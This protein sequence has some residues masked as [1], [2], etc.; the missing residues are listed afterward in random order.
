MA[1]SARCRRDL[2]HR[3]SRKGSAGPGVRRRAGTTGST[4]RHA[5]DS[6]SNRC[7]H[8]DLLT[9]VAEEVGAAGIALQ[10]PRGVLVV[11]VEL[12]EQRPFTPGSHTLLTLLAARLGQGLHRVYQLDEQ[13]ETASGPA[14]RHARPPTL[15]EGFAVRYRPANRPLQVGGDWYDVVDL[16][17]GRIAVIVGD[18]VGH[19]L[20]R[21]HRDGSAAQRLPR[22]AARAAQSR[23]GAGRAPTASLRVCRSPDAPPHSAQCSTPPPVNS[24]TPARAIRRRSWCTPTAPPSGWTADTGY[25]WR[26]RGTGPD[27]KPASRCRRAATL[28]LY[29]DG[30]VER[31]GTSI[32]DGMARAADL[33]QGCRSQALDQVA[34]HSCPDSSPRGRYPDDVAMLLYRQP[35]PLTNFAAD[36][37]HLASSPPPGAAG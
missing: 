24:S 14:A 3:H 25:P 11:W 37:N 7:V 19:G 27:P 34:E 35:V 20:P 21:R 8:A 23:R 26:S 22:L 29:T 9:T 33:V 5:S 4:C 16:G 30:L 17:D 15:P 1:G 2:L 6:R 36:A 10:Y 18:C 12:T 28:L 31:R 32:D 13:R